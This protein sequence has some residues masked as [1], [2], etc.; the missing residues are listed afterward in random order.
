MTNHPD[1]DEPEHTASQTE[2]A[3]TALA[4]HG[5]R[6]SQDEPDPRPAP[7][8]DTLAGAV[9]EMMDGLAGTLRDTSLEA[10]LPDL[11]WSLVNVFHRRI[12]R[13]QRE[14]D[15]NEDAQKAGQKQQ[16]GSEI[17]SVELERLIAEGQVLLGRRDA[18]ESLRDL[19]DTRFEQILGM[20]WRPYSGSMVNH[21]AMTAAVIASRDFVRAKRQTETQILIP[22]GTRIVFSGGLDFNDHGL[23]FAALDKVK[24]KYP[25]MVLL[26]TANRV[27]A[28]RI[29]IG[30]AA[31]RKVTAIGF[32]MDKNLHGN[33]APF[34]RNDRMVEEMPKGA[35]IAPGTGIQEQLARK[36]TEIGVRPW[37][38]GE[39][40]K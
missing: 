34:K 24:A 17:R 30:W 21:R 19:A 15:T 25:D 37:R 8:D 20:A 9:A 33:A 2:E 27:G 35:V 18:I 22:A 40:A 3:M 1:D 6:P 28:D 39:A 29:A 12:D 4:L 5:Y 32:G 11:L 38:I 13:V 31:S 36:L 14:L 23:I 16:D 26:H 7:D 10:D